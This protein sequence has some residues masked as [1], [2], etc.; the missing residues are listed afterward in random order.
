MAAKK[1]G[2]SNPTSTVILQTTKTQKYA[3]DGE[4]QEESSIFLDENNM[5]VIETLGAPT[6]AGA[7][8]TEEDSF[9]ANK[10]KIDDATSGESGI[11]TGDEL[12]IQDSNL[13]TMDQN[14]LDQMSTGG[15]GAAG[16]MGNAD[17]AFEELMATVTVSAKEQ[18]QS[19]YIPDWVQVEWGLMKNAGAEGEDLVPVPAC[20]AQSGV[21]EKSSNYVFDM[22][23]DFHS[24]FI[25]APVFLKGLGNDLAANTGGTVSQSM[26]ERYGAHDVIRTVLGKVWIR[27][28]VGSGMFMPPI[29]FAQ[30]G[31]GTMDMAS[32][33]SSA[34]S[35]Y[36][37]DT[38]ITPDTPRVEQ[39]LSFYAFVWAQGQ[40]TSPGAGYI[41]ANPQGPFG[42]SDDDGLYTQERV[43]ITN[44]TPVPNGLG[45][46]L[47]AEAV[48]DAS[49]IWEIWAEWKKNNDLP[50]FESIRGR[51]ELDQAGNNPL[52]RF[53]YDHVHKISTPFTYK[54]TVE[55]NIS[56]P[57]VVKLDPKYNFLIENYESYIGQTPTIPESILPH[58]LLIAAKYQGSSAVQDIADP[59]GL[60]H[61][62][63][64]SLDGAIPDAF[65]THI[66]G[67][68][69]QET[70]EF[71]PE[72]LKN[73]S[74]GQY[75]DAWALAIEKAKNGLL[76]AFGAINKNSELQK[77]ANDYKTQILIPKEW[78][79]AAYGSLEKM[80]GK[81][82]MMVELAF[83]APRS[84]QVMDLL[85]GG[86]IL[87]DPESI[88]FTPSS[89]ATEYPGLWYALLR[90][91]IDGKDPCVEENSVVVPNTY[92]VGGAPTRKR[93]LK[94]MDFLDF[95][96]KFNNVET[97]YLNMDQTS[98]IHYIQNV[99]PVATII[100]TGLTDRNRNETK[101]LFAAV[102]L[103]EGSQH[104]VTDLSAATNILIE[105]M[106]DLIKEKT[107]TYTDI[108]EGKIA[109]SET[110]FWKITKHGL[111]EDGNIIDDP[112]QTFYYPNIKEAN[113]FELLD[114]Q[115]KYG[116]DYVYEITAI[117]IVF[118]TEYELKNVL[119]PI[120]STGGKFDSSNP[121]LATWKANTIFEDEEGNI[122][123]PDLWVQ[124][125]NSSGNE[126]E[127]WA[128]DPIFVPSDLD[129]GWQDIVLEDGFGGYWADSAIYNYQTKDFLSFLQHSNAAGMRSPTRFGNITPNTQLTVLDGIRPANDP[130]W[131]I[132]GTKLSLPSN[133]ATH[134]TLSIDVLS[135][136]SV[137][138]IEAPYHSTLVKVLDRPPLPPLVTT[139]PYKDMNDKYLLTLEGN[140]GEL[141]AEPI[142]LRL[143]D[144]E[145][146]EKQI[147]AQGS[148][149]PPMLNF[150][151]DDTPEAFEIFRIDPPETE[152][153]IMSNENE[154][155]YPPTSYDSFRK[156]ANYRQLL[157]PDTVS[158][159][160]VENIK[161]N[162]TYYYTF[163]SK[164]H[165]DN[166]SNPTEVYEIKIV[167]D[168]GATYLLTKLYEFPKIKRTNTKKMKKYLNLV[169][170][171]EQTMKV[172]T[173]GQNTNS[174]NVKLGTAEDSI[175]DSGKTFK[176]RLTSKKTGRKMD[177]N[178]KF[179]IKN[180]ITKEEKDPTNPLSEI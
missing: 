29:V 31:L 24:L 177:V 52:T 22:T 54:E 48:D 178:V 6:I 8:T 123:H 139:V 17:P 108:L 61:H 120:V 64:L 104:Q 168:A 141:N 111:D 147:L 42:Q 169:P 137:R 12:D 68:T 113:Y 84:G 180:N 45:A 78:S 164:D 122:I 86:E 7:D 34:K 131:G 100:P 88:D 128:G 152:S 62:K 27:R 161:P 166:I 129:L 43:Q 44:V 106:D 138:I 25:R 114:S 150:Y 82:P 18:I 56:N 115:V 101:S 127:T 2:A 165:H 3:D 157:A 103:V 175:F 1:G 119:T 90:A 19:A 20:Q 110:L 32:A 112:I 159:S 170:V 57:L 35:T 163:R 51:V 121:N 53:K 89:E 155:F 117:N 87:P 83:S 30:S 5:P 67:S 81:F 133:I 144:E 99:E 92:S 160:L 16:A 98:G 142:S 39:K 97:S 74:G 75:F 143:E 38:A 15:M 130:S 80:K 60:N 50:L 93:L 73:V 13:A 77:L 71:T 66:V 76:P 162:L 70:G 91:F 140:T 135:R 63:F 109:C 158:K 94:E 36:H 107:R 149:E 102:D 41:P 134:W 69:D 145:L 11:P 85:R 125:Y 126:L 96:A 179:D 9:A 174:T 148:P 79:P 37:G 14:E 40:N 171:L 33:L 55:Q 116:K 59:T 153:E 58:A 72:Y 65:I 49:E 47:A 28:T 173:E 172:E 95:L 167:D 118:G 10:N 124:E 26:I 4:P 176:I 136:P 146:I 46:G 151:A 156:K 21:T 132:P 105:G 154:Q 23:S